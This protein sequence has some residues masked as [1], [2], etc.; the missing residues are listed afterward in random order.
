MKKLEHLKRLGMSII[1]SAVPVTLE[2]CIEIIKYLIGYIKKP[3]T[4]LEPDYTPSNYHIIN[5]AIAWF[6]LLL[7]VVAISIF[8]ILKFL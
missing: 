7:P 8:V 3:L 2:V 4:F 5:R 1:R 6:M